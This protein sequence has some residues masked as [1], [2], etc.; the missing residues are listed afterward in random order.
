VDDGA[1]RLEKYRQIAEKNEYHPNPNVDHT[2]CGMPSW[3]CGKSCS[4]CDHGPH[5]ADCPTRWV[6]PEWMDDVAQ[7]VFKYMRPT[8]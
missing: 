7:S 8:S 1:A 6:I 3:M 5:A 4:Y 2:T